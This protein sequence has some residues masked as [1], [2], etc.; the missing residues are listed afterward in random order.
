MHNNIKLEE[1][2]LDLRFFQD[3][4]NE[5]GQIGSLLRDHLM[6]KKLDIDLEAFEG[7]SGNGESKLLPMFSN[8]DTLK[9]LKSFRFNL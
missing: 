6:L 1:L 7:N 9:N 8:L 2:I 5:L 3:V 4:K